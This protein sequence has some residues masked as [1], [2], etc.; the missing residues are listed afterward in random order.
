LVNLETLINKNK[1]NIKLIN[2]NY[3]QW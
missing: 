3:F 2:T 1:P